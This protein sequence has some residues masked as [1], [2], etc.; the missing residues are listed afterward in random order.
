MKHLLKP[1]ISINKNKPEVLI[2]EL[3]LLFSNCDDENHLIVDC[4]ERRIMCN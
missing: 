1:V 4:S 3:T 2:F